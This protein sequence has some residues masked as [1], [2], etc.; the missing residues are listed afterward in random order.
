MNTFGVN[1]WL[2]DEAV[3][4]A[5]WGRKKAYGSSVVQEFNMG[6]GYSF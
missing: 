6:V 1:W 3:L 5:D 2:T 4:K